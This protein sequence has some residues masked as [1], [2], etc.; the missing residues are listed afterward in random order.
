MLRNI[1]DNLQARVILGNLFIDL[2]GGSVLL[3]VVK[4]ELLNL[5]SCQSVACNQYCIHLIKSNN[6][7]NS[8][9]TKKKIFNVVSSAVDWVFF[10]SP[11][12][13]FN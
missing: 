5:Q 12:P 13:S 2:E 7:R 3:S 4:I 9:A 1:F 6:Q 8:V 10:S 11:H